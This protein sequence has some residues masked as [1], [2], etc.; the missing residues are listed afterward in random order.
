M[1]LQAAFSSPPWRGMPLEILAALTLAYLRP[2]Q[3]GLKLPLPLLS[4]ELLQASAR[5]GSWD[6]TFLPTVGIVCPLTA[7][8][9]ALHPHQ[10]CGKGPPDWL[11]WAWKT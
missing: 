5:E 1:N 2:D 6:A 7:P 3:P 8:L 9:A 10:E 11:T 4:K